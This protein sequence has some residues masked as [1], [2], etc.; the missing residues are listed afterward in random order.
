ML[1]SWRR[2]VPVDR[3]QTMALGS[4]KRAWDMLVGGD[5]SSEQRSLPQV[6][7]RSGVLRGHAGYLATTTIS[8]R[9][10][11]F[12]IGSAAQSLVDD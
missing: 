1:V 7:E 11:I 8:L 4:L 2:I 6:T 9:V 10:G 12:W 5:C 3:G